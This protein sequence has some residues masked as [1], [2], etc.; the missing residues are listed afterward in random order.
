[1]PRLDGSQ[2]VMWLFGGSVGLEQWRHEPPVLVRS[3]LAV[4]AFA[5]RGAAEILRGKKRKEYTVSQRSGASSPVLPLKPTLELPAKPLA[6]MPQDGS[7]V[8]TVRTNCVCK[9]RFSSM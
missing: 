3:C 4:D 1:M 9:C 8:A 6:W 2:R 7:D 5:Q